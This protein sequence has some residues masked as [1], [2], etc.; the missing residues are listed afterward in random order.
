MEKT[1]KKNSGL[2]GKNI[3]IYGKHAK[4]MKALA[5]KFGTEQNQG[6]F[7]RNL[8]VYI[9]APIIGKLFN[10]KADVDKTIDEDTK[11]FLE[12]V[13]ESIEELRMNYRIIM[14]L[15]DRDS[16]DLE[17]RINR[18]FRY[19]KNDEKREYGDKVFSS[20]VLGGIEV[21]YEKLIGNE[22]NTDR[23]VEN[24]FEFIE[25]LKD[26]YADTYDVNELIKL[27]SK[28]SQL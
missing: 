4:Y 8:D 19:D 26:T 2:F 27:S 10:R 28:S 1:A 14:M 11:I 24:A 6:F 9:A 21:L 12:Q 18:A 5:N 16:V 22:T 3:I 25:D 15:E 20:Y 7:K 17:E 13:N 23:L